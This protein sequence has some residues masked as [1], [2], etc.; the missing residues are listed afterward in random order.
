M[1]KLT[2]EQAELVR[3][4]EEQARKAE[5]TTNLRMI[6]K[7][8]GL[9]DEYPLPENCRVDGA[10][11]ARRVELCVLG[12][13]EPVGVYPLNSM[14]AQAIFDEILNTIVFHGV[15]FGSHRDKKLDA[16]IHG[17]INQMAGM[18]AREQIDASFQ[19]LVSRTRLERLRYYQPT[20]LLAEKKTNLVG[21]SRPTEQEKRRL[22][23]KLHLAQ[24][25]DK[26]TM[27]IHNFIH[28]LIPQRGFLL[29]P[30]SGGV[31]GMNPHR[32]D[33][34]N[35]ATVFGRWITRHYL[36]EQ[37]LRHTGGAKEGTHEWA[38]ERAAEDFFYGLGSEQE[39]K[40][41]DQLCLAI[42]KPQLQQADDYPE[43][44]APPPSLASTITR[45][46]EADTHSYPSLSDSGRSSR[47]SSVS[48]DN[49]VGPPTPPPTPP[50]VAAVIAV[51]PPA[52]QQLFTTTEKKPSDLMEELLKLLETW[53]RE[54]AAGRTK[55]AETKLFLGLR[56]N[57]DN[58][59]SL[60]L[61]EA[62]PPGVTQD[63]MLRLSTA[64]TYFSTHKPATTD[65][66]QL[67]SISAL[68]SAKQ[69]TDAILQKQSSKKPTGW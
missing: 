53:M 34:V 22:A 62:I 56:S 25:R 68:E 29:E 61:K 16:T 44:I 30:Q 4:F 54:H 52:K 33:D 46:T 27:C 3:Q 9:A 41:F 32:D 63:Q 1:A 60:C 31:R 26:L 10:A 15:K 50:I 58:L 13:L 23:E 35:V 28:P 17:L 7:I 38:I 5:R 64:L 37:Y 55:T 42:T 65:T 20:P 40:L 24:N 8:L 12:V 2:R 69:W 43:T 14:K 36:G 67:R 19:L 51:A 57:E 48:S 21:G 18:E 11:L 39:S 6:S 66:Q 45:V 59:R 47:Y 49:F